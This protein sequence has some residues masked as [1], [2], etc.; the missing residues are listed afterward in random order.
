MTPEKLLAL[1][2]GREDAF[3]LSGPD[4]GYIAK[5]QPPRA[6]H[7][8][9]HLR[10]A[11]R[12]GRYPLRTDGTCLWAVL[13]VDGKGVVPVLDLVAVLRRHGIPF[14]VERSK[15]KGWHLWVWF[16]MPIPGWKARAVLR[17]LAAEA[18]W[19]DTEVFPKQDDL[20]THGLGSFMNLP[21]QGA[22]VKE[23]R[24]LFVDLSKEQWPPYTDQLAY[25]ESIPKISETDLDHIIAAKGLRP[26]EERTASSGNGRAAPVGDT[27]PD[28]TRNITL[29][30][31][32]G[33]MRRR[34]MSPEAILAA[35][36][37]ENAKCAPPLGDEELRRIA[38]SVG[39][40]EPT[41]SPPKGAPPKAKG[42]KVFPP[43]VSPTEPWPDP[44]D[45]QVLLAGIE[46]GLRRFVVADAAAHTAVGLWVIAS[47]A[48]ECFDLFPFLAIS[49]PTKRCGKTTLLS[50]LARLLPQPLATSNISPAAVYRVIQNCRPTLLMD[51]VDTFVPD[52]VELRGILNS[53]HSKDLAFVVRSV[54]EGANQHPERFSTWCPKVLSQIGRPPDTWADR[55]VLLSLRRR[56]KNEPVERARRKAPECLRD[57]GR[58]AARWAKDHAE[59]LGALTPDIPNELDDRACDNW[60]PLLM[61]ADLIGGEWPKKAREAAK[62]LS[63]GRDA[64]DEGAGIR[65]LADVRGVFQARNAERLSS[66]DVVCGLLCDEEQGWG[67]Y[68]KGQKPIDQRGVAR[69]LKPF[70]VRAKDIRFE[71][72]VAR[73]YE[74]VAFSDA[75]TRYLPL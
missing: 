71:T 45:G 8:R 21:W 12:I 74:S 11:I 72:G 17:S 33:S 6:I 67:T 27:I 38:A 51:E 35:L 53:G 68:R 48:F 37:V 18:G 32:A 49:S 59:T 28:H 3:G 14:A 15:A 9:E 56:A 66:A 39:R 30:S 29:T 10:G 31:L 46:Q 19:P 44:V 5:R 58:M 36:R 47:H 25:L 54:G 63:G 69:L 65:L 2:P 41:T 61:I 57:L 64:E 23:G 60:E 26:P 24:T 52:N 55:S 70:G 75:W 34:G 73:G 7:A 13:D 40:Y 1:F 62:T 20:A 42:P 43:L 50:V 4:S 22:S 16:A